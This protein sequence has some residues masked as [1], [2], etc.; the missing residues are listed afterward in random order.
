MRLALRNEKIAQGIPLGVQAKI[1]KYSGDSSDEEINTVPIGY[2]Y[3]DNFP[4]FAGSK[5]KQGGKARGLQN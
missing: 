5:P 1:P 4:S 2:K 3:E